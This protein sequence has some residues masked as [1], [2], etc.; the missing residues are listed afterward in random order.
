MNGRGGN[1]STSSNRRSRGS[2][3]SGRPTGTDESPDGRG[4]GETRSNRPQGRA[5]GQRRRAAGGPS[6]TLLSTTLKVDDSVWGFTQP[7][8][9][10]RTFMGWSQ[11][12][13]VFVFKNSAHRFLVFSTTGETLRKLRSNN[14]ASEN[15]S[16][17][18]SFLFPNNERF[19]NLL[20]QSLN[21]L[22]F[23]PSIGASTEAS[24]LPIQIYFGTAVR[25]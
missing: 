7:T 17:I 6:I 23:G 22:A 21:C 20:T 19:T 15:H 8:G 13:V 18:F 12:S 9:R 10:H 3:A 11:H 5:V 4:R 1:G 25:T 14:K 24:T 2:R 16:G